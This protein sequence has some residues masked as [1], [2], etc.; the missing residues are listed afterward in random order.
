MRNDRDPPVLLDDR[1]LDLV[2]P[3]EP[4]TLAG[5]AEL[6]YGI[7]GIRPSIFYDLGWAGDRR[8]W[9]DQGRALSG[10]GVGV[11]FL[12]GLIR[13]DVATGLRPSRGVRADLTLE[14]RF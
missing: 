9:R 6:G 2:E 11:S 5:R 8:S 12:D 7:P 10:A 14:A 1:V 4:V 13:L 3:L